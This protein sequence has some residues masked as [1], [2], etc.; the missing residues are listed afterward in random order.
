MSSHRYVAEYDD[1]DY[2]EYGEYDQ[3]P[4]DP[5]R[6]YEDVESYEPYEPFDD[7]VVPEDSRAGRGV[8]RVLSGA[9]GLILT[10][11]AL[12]LLAW[13]GLRQQMLVQATLSTQR[14]VFGIGLLVG[15]GILLLAVGLLGALSATGP[16]VGGLVWGVAPGVAAAAVPEWGFRLVKYLPQNDVTYGVTSWL[17]IGGLLGTGLLLIGAGLAARLARR[18]R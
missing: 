15:G 11:V 16:I 4:K 1:E 5:R 8:R 9:G 10:P 13:G 18:R 7:D 17:F 6:P 3:Q 12:G 2:Q 14:D